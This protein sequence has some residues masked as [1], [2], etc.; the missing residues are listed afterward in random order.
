MVTTT[1]LLNITETFGT[2]L[3]FEPLLM[4]ISKQIRVIDGRTI[5]HRSS[6]V[7]LGAG[8]ADIRAAGGADDQR[9]GRGTGH[10]GG[11]DGRGA[12][13]AP[14]VRGVLEMLQD[15]ELEV[16]VVHLGGDEGLDVRL[17]EGLLAVGG[18]AVEAGDLGGVDQAGGVAGQALDAVDMDLAGVDVDHGFGGE[19]VKADGAGHADGVGGGDGGARRRLGG[20]RGGN[21]VR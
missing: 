12:R 11:Q 17:F 21:G 19:V 14:D 7:G 8:G 4:E 18:G 16:A 3:D 20:G 5:A 13:G 9:G 15:Q 6:V 1:I 10:V 2:F